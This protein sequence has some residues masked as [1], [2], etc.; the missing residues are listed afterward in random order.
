M[1][2]CRSKR[3]ADN[4]ALREGITRSASSSTTRKLPSSSNATCA[5]AS[6]ADITPADQRRR[7]CC[8]Y[9]TRFPVL[10]NQAL[11]ATPGL[12]FS[13]VRDACTFP[14]VIRMPNRICHCSRDAQNL[15]I[16]CLSPSSLLI[17]LSKHKD[18]MHPHSALGLRIL[19]FLKHTTAITLWKESAFWKWKP[20]NSSGRKKDGIWHLYC[21]VSKKKCTCLLR[22]DRLIPLCAR[23]D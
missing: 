7:N 5:R 11:R 21:R 4:T 1:A 22:P 9:H 19:Y 23:S 15:L 17:A 8:H 10:E 14:K 2:W 12:Q 3:A 16:Y 13:I 18:A 6:C 20:A